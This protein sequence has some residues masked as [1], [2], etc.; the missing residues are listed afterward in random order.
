M[1]DPHANWPPVI[2]SAQRPR[3]IYWRDVALTL[4]AWLALIIILYTELDLIVNA[5][6]YLMRV[7]DVVVDAQLELFWRRLQP[8]LWLMAALVG[9]LAVATLLSRDRREKALKAAP[10]P[11]LPEATLAA[12]AQL[13]EAALALARTHRIA[14][15]HVTESGGLLVEEGGLPP[16]SGE[17]K[18]GA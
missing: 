5:I 12:R 4:L 7:P 17:G 8:L 18:E 13:D 6:Q 14:V 9:M 1:T 16:Q 2:T 11:P 10:P 15:V 3:Y